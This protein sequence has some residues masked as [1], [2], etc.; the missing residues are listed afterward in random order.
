M[1]TSRYGS[2]S[3]VVGDGRSTCAGG[4]IRRRR[5]LR[6]AHGEIVKLVGSGGLTK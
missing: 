1:V 4:G 5:V 3:E 6:P 2:A